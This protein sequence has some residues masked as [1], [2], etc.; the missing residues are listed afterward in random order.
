VQV[1]ARDDALQALVPLLGLRVE[2]G[3]RVVLLTVDAQGAVWVNLFCLVKESVVDD[4]FADVAFHVHRR[5]L[6]LLGVNHVLNRLQGCWVHIWFT[7][8]TA[9]LRLLL[10][11]SLWC[12]NFAHLVQKSI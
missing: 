9:S 8:F 5:L 12:L 4:A 2:R 1:F 10:R 6:L 3:W 7:L 11:G